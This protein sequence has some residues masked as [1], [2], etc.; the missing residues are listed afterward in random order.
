[1][2]AELVYHCDF[3]GYTGTKAEVMRHEAKH[4][5]LTLSDYETWLSLDRKVKKMS[6]LCEDCHS[7]TTLKYFDLAV[8]ELLA[9]EAEHNLKG[10]HI[11]AG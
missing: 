11:S 6:H 2:Y 9:F 5:G 3:C 7:E 4:F 1:M 8:E 10:L